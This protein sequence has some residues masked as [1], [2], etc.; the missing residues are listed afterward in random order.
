MCNRQSQKIFIVLVI[1]YLSLLNRLFLFLHKVHQV[2]CS[3]VVKPCLVSNHQYFHFSKSIPNLFLEME[4]PFWFW[5]KLWWVF[6]CLL[7]FQ[8]S[9]CHFQKIIS[10][11]CIQHRWPFFHNNFIHLLILQV[12]D[13]KFH[14]QM[15]Q[16][17]QGI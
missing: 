14:T 2:P 11:T 3:K 17:F 4:N 5:Q 10:H 15:S 1:I 7:I 6:P 8:A 9:I 13:G 12:V 16:S